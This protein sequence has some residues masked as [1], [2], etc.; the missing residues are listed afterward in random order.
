MN[1]LSEYQIKILD[2]LQL[3][4]NKNIIK[5]PK[6]LKNLTLELPPKDHKAD[7]SCNAALILSKI[8][9]KNPIEIAD[10]LKAHF[11]KKFIEFKDITVANPGFLNISFNDKFWNDYLI[12]I[13]KFDKKYGSIK[14]NK[15]K[16]NVEFVSANPTGPLHVGHCRGAVIGDVISRLLEFNGHKVVKEFYVNDYGNQIKNFVLSV[17]HRILEIV[18]K[19]NFPNNLNLY[20]GEYIIDIAKKIIKEKKIKKFNSIDKIYDT[21]VDESIK[22]SMLLIKS[23]LNDLDIKHNNFVYESQLIKKKISCQ[24][25]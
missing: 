20:P 19:K 6:N 23:N 9:E 13:I 18:E 12:K 3:L 10:I 25:N 5:V 21:L 17:Y 11:L 8:N 7:I 14:Q 15:K 22:Y 1:L 4:S 24:N 2:Y 16:Y